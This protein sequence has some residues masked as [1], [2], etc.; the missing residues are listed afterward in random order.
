MAVTVVPYNDSLMNMLKAMNLGSDTLKVCLLTAAYTPDVDNHTTYADV[1]ANELAGSG[2][3]TTGGAT[4]SSNAVTADDTNNRA[5]FDAV[6]VTWPALTMSAAAQYAAIYN[7]S[8]SNNLLLYVDFGD[9]IDS[10]GSD[11]TLIWHSN[12]I[13]YIGT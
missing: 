2:N 8:D 4:M 12:G 1:S 6:D 9:T 7:T 13:F 11:F 10:G 5:K 3:Y